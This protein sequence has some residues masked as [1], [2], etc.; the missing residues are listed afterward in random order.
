MKI[1]A[2][3]STALIAGAWT[4][5]TF[6]LF[7]GWTPPPGMSDHLVTAIYLLGC[8]IL[9]IIPAVFFAYG[10]DLKRWDPDY[11]HQPHAQA[12]IS[13]IWVRGGFWLLGSIVCSVAIWLAR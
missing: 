13:E 5:L 11:V 4:S 9:W 3:R 8:M 1:Q 6:A 2:T 12:E 7:G 10:F